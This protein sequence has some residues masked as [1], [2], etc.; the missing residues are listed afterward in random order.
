M[1]KAIDDLK[2]EHEAILA[3]LQ[4]LN[5]MI[6]SGEQVPADELN[7][8]IGFLKEFADKCHHSKEEDILFPALTR[9]GLPLEGGP[10]GVMLGEHVQGREYIQAMENAAEGSPDYAGFAKS[11]RQYAELLRQHIQKE[12]NVLFVMAEKLLSAEQLD[13]IYEAFEQHE[14]RNIGHG[15][16]E[17]LHKML[18]GY[19]DRYGV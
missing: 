7:G 14:E 19:R 6:D 12:N 4:V 15:R 2:H 9:A 13:E 18:E 11:A 1:S 3:A 8:F 16:H 5:S 10:V 17:E